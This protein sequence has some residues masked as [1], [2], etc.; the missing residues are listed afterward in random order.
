MSVGEAEE[1]S[2]R[3]PLHTQ[4][5]SNP[6]LKTLLLSLL[7]WQDGEVEEFMCMAVHRVAEI[8]ATTNEVG[9]AAA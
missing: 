2:M 1:E 7:R 8:V 9:G 6:F 4:V 3:L 5:A